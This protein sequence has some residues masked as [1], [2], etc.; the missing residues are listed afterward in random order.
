[1]SDDN[2][3]KRIGILTFHTAI[4]YGAVLQAYAL[5]KYLNEQGYDCEVIDYQCKKIN[6]N[7]KILKIKSK[8]LKKIIISFLKAPLLFLQR[9]KFKK[10]V[11]NNIRLSNQK[12]YP[13]NI[14]SS[15]KYY[16][17]FITGS[18]QV[19]NLSLTNNDMSYFLDFATK[20]RISY[21]ASNGTEEI[22]EKDFKK[23][24]NY[25]QK[26]SAISVR[27]KGLQNSLMNKISISI[28]KVL[29]PVFLLDVESWN[30]LLPN[31]NC[32]EKYILAYII[33]EK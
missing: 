30:N 22:S 7:Y 26:F 28:I 21:A 19:W 14:T 31:F 29:D 16:D 6:D 12:Y 3:K 9:K 20:K 10:F 4:N 27:E 18:D 11:I 13:Y 2:N 5:Q 33:H 17:C 1:M 23:V 8:N 15:N 24:S 32:K 25:L